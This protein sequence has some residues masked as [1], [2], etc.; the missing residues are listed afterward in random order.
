MR[1][2]R[3]LELHVAHGCNLT[4]ESCSHYSNQGHTGLVALADADAWM[5]GWSRRLE[6]AAGAEG[7]FAAG[8]RADD[9]SAAFRVRHAGASALAADPSANRHQR[10]L[11]PSASDFARRV[12]GRSQC[13]SL[14]LHTS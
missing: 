10:L 5:A 13:R 12:A 7:L 14:S 2:L 3:N 1:I 11:P 8:R 6:P 9:S 4:C